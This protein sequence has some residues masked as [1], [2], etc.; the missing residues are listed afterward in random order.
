MTYGNIRVTFF[1]F[2]ELG[3]VVLG[4]GILMIAGEFDLSVGSVFALSPLMMVHRRR[5][6]GLRS[7]RSRI[8]LGFVVALFVGYLN[9]WITIQFQHPELRHHA[10]HDVHGALRRG[11]AVR[12]LPAAV[13]RRLPA[14]GSSSSD[15]GL[16]RASMIW[17]VGFAVILGVMLHF[18]NLGNWIYATGGQPQAAADM[19][20]NTRRVKLFCFMLCSL[21][22]RLCRHG[23]DLPAQV[24]DA[25]ARRRRRAAGDRRRGDRRH[26]R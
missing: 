9:G 16:F 12:R 11:G 23:H 10:R 15:L 1:A 5:P 24:G 2:P 18:S 4:V 3:I 19:G 26:R 8:A 25:G 6:L 13:P 20:I 17:F 7:L 22:R 14:S 21:P